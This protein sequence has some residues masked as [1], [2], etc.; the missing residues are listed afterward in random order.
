MRFK[1]GIH[2]IIRTAIG[3]AVM[4][5]V[6][7]AVLH[8]RAE[9]ST[10]EQLAIKANKVD[11]VSR[12][13]M[14]LAM[15]SEAEKSAVMAVIDQ[16][17]LAF[18]EQARAAT[19]DVARNT[20]EL[21]ELLKAGG[22]RGEKD[23][24][25]QFGKVFADYR[26]IGSDLLAMAVKN[27]NVKAYGLA[28]GPAADALKEMDTALSRLASKSAGSAGASG[29]AALA[30]GAQ[31]AA[32]RIQT[33]LAP[34]I[35]EESDQKMDALEA[36]MAKED[37]QVRKALDGLAALLK[38]RGDPDLE[39]AAADYSRFSEVRGRILALSRENTN[40]R[41]LAVSLG[42]KRKVLFMCQDV[43]S[44][45]QQAILEEPIAGVNY[46]PKSNPRRLDAGKPG[47][48]DEH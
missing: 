11:L 33:L 37:L 48:K 13:R 36:L 6:F 12:M 7:F 16:D 38:S 29:V 42:Q 44:S 10:A 1:P 20:G 17:S 27:T 43:L 28:F 8:F 46:G 45:L 40:V 2:D 19:A 14:A 31:T 26:R 22:T 34:H 24:L 9:H 15:G 39:T 18:A 30:F 35:A 21:E 32:L 5:A 47:D 4:F 3:A 23:L 41:S 25:D